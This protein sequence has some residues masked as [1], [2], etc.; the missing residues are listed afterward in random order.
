MV[1]PSRPYADTGL[2]PSREWK[3]S[4]APVGRTRMD[5]PGQEQWRAGPR[6]RISLP[7]PGSQQRTGS[8]RAYVGVIRVRAGNSPS[9][10][11]TGSFVPGTDGSNPSPSAGES[12][13]TSRPTPAL[14]HLHIAGRSGLLNH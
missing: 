12:V 4:N 3:G 11:K 9:A 5:R 8:P 7:P 1:K 2:R 13:L 10:T 6:V 14:I